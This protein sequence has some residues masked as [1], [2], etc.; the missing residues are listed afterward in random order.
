MTVC[1]SLSP[2][3]PDRSRAEMWTNTS[4]PPLFGVTKPYPLSALNHFT[5]PVSSTDG[6]FDG[7]AWALDRRDG[8]GVALPVL[9]L[10]TSVM[11]GPLWPGPT[12]TSRVS[13][14]EQRRSHIG[15]ARC[16]AGTHRQTHR[17]VQRS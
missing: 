8:I 2:C 17:R 3:M 12:R 15:S 11:C 5:V 4:L 7:V 13:P 1:P 9:T 14:A 6:P 16:Y 10:S